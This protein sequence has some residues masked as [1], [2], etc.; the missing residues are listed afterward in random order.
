MKIALA[1]ESLL[2]AALLLRQLWAM[3][4]KAIDDYNEDLRKREGALIRWEAHEASRQERFDDISR[5]I[6]PTN[7]SE[8]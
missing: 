3:I 8:V 4:N 7:R 2:L 6:A 5:Q 1:I